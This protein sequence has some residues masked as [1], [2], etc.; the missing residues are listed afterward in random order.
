MADANI[1]IIGRVVKLNIAD[2]DIVNLPAKIDTGAYIS[3]IWATKI[4]DK[5]G[6]LSYTLLGPKSP[7]YSGKLITTKDYKIVIIQNSFGHS[8]TRYSVP[9]KVEIGGRKV[10]AR[11]TLA[12]RGLKSYPALI[13][14]R[15]LNKR[16]LVDVSHG[17]PLA[18]SN[19]R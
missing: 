5:D 19:W 14:R 16:F 18:K 6:Q 7:F 10:K 11:F 1:Q 4:K 12:N 3:A 9:L 8:E 17:S 13:G 2:S 15:L